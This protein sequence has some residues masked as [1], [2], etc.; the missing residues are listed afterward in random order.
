MVI[1]ESHATIPQ[2]HAMYGGDYTRKKNLVDFG[3]RLP[4]AFDNRPLK[5]KEFE[6]KINQ[7]IFVSATPADYEMEKTEGVFVEQIIRPTGLL[8]PVIK[9]KPVST[10]VDD[11]LEQI[12]ERI[13]TRQKILVTTLTKR[14][15]EDLTQYLTRAG[16]KAR[17]MHSE[18]DTLERSKIIRGLRLGEF[19]VLV[20]INLLREG[21]DLPEV[22]LVAIL[23]ADKAG[24]L[25]SERSLIQTAGRA[26]RNIDGTVIFYADSIT[27]AMQ[28]TISETER[29]REKQIQYNLDHN[30]TPESIKKNIDDIMASTRVAEGYKEAAK[31]NIS[32]Q[33]KFKEY[34]DLDSKEKVI[35]LLER[36][37]KE[38]ADNLEFEKAAELRDR[39]LEI[40][41]LQ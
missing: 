9:V 18:I 14:M 1:D 8:D 22:S 13:K 33:E 6:N 19:D 40:T 3:F 39:I 25:R 26:A 29:R 15:S 27:D 17:Y 30:I 36:E 28:K 5:F 24:F 23:D 7:L 41:G 2:I 12:R 20:G 38:A 34:L 32:A 31:K 37:M 35:S 10:Q 21:L 4:S 11:L 16:I